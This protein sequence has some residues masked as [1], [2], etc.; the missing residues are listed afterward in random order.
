MK[1]KIVCIMTLVVA[2]P[3]QAIGEFRHTTKLRS[4]DYFLKSR[5][6]HK[7]PVFDE[8]KTVD[9]GATIGIGSDCGKIN[10]E[11]TL[12]SS[13]GNLLNAE[14]YFA[15]LG[16]DILPNATLLGICYMS[17]T[18][19]SI[20]KHTQVS[21]HWM[22][23]MRLDQCALIDKY[24]DSRV[25]DYYQER[26]SCV[27]S[28][29]QKTDGDMENAMG[30]CQGSGLWDGLSSWAGG[31]DGKVRTNKLI[32]SSAEWA[33]FSGEQAQGAVDLVKSLVGDTVVEGGNIRVEYGP[34]R[35]SA[36]TPRTYLQS[37]EN[38]TYEKL[39]RT[40]LRKVEVYGGRKGIER[41]VTDEEL[42]SITPQVETPLVDR[43]TLRALAAMPH[44]QRWDACRKLSDTVAGTVF[45]TD[46]H[47]SLDILTTLS[48]N[49][50]LPPNR[51]AEIEQKRKA[52][53]ESV[54]MTVALKNERNQPLNAVLSQ[55]NEEGQ[56]FQS[57]AMA[58]ELDQDSQKVE[59]QRIR[60][61]FMDCSDSVMCER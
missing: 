9:L 17:P 51:K 54:E 8:Y 29:I 15:N 48:Q 40:T 59:N 55:I 53:K 28:S 35:Q 33:G 23:K 25:E 21:A 24:V 5:Q 7:D 26:Q 45:S 2:I 61:T 36:L 37:V 41:L 57:E 4:D 38:D 3:S 30:S 56:R 12:R 11:S 14:K 18:W 27:R 10:F 46:I 43:Q 44:K 50:N 47:R 34:R 13:F 31:S 42:K 32:E 16:R 1:L 6:D 19:C 52:L 20:V 39:C 22:S 60:N 49:P 58:E